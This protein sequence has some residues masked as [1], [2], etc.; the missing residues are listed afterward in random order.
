MRPP[1][2][3]RALE[4]GQSQISA[5]TSSTVT[6]SGNV[7]FREDIVES[8]IR[9]TVVVSNSHP[10]IL[11]PLEMVSGEESCPS[12]LEALP[13]ARVPMRNRR[14]QTNP[15]HEVPNLFRQEPLQQNPPRYVEGGILRNGPLVHT[16][17]TMLPNREACWIQTQLRNDQD[18]PI[19]FLA[20]PHSWQGSHPSGWSPSDTPE[21][22]DNRQSGWISYLEGLP[23]N[24]GGPSVFSCG[25]LPFNPGGGVPGFQGQGSPGPLASLVEVFQD[26]WLPRRRSP[27]SLWTPWWRFPWSSC[28]LYPLAEVP[29]V[30]PAPERWFFRSP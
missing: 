28:T 1:S 6:Q 23:R 30:H 26:P 5:P 18:R 12:S 29:L 3:L 8:V 15:Q 14:E 7:P 9:T 21:L 2:L 22:W 25:G 27:R 24:F 16:P 11:S 4:R 10:S 13:R 19:A 20:D 17:Q